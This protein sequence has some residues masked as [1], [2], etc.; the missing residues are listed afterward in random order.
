MSNAYFTAEATGKIYVIDGFLS[1][2]DNLTQNAF[3]FPFPFKSYKDTQ[4][5]DFS[6]QKNEISGSFIIMQRSDDYTAGTGTPS[7]YDTEE[8]RAYLKDAIFSSIGTI[9][10]TDT[11]GTDYSGRLTSIEI[12][13]QGD[14]PLQYACS[15]SLVIGSTFTGEILEEDQ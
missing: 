6:G 7:S 5:V 15:F 14:E 12:T 1:L 4:L 10:L 8:Q 3:V 11:D 2:R 13:K 9:T